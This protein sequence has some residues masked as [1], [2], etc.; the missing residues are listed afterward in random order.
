VRIS[1]NAKV[2]IEDLKKLN[3]DA[4]NCLHWGGKL[5]DIFKKNYYFIFNFFFEFLREILIDF[6]IIFL[7][8]SYISFVNQ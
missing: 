1:G 6:F 8:F 2:G 4:K 5:S 3:K 7:S